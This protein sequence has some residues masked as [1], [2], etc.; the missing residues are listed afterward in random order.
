LRSESLRLKKRLDDGRVSLNIDERNQEKADDK[1]RRDKEKAL[2]E[3]NDKELNIV[4]KF[5]I[6][7]GKVSLVNKDD[8]KDKEKKAKEDGD[9]EPENFDFHLNEAL[10]IFS[11]WLDIVSKK[12]TAVAQKPAA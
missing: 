6:Q 3:Q 4:E 7:K 8:K 11:D 12:E 5:D 10:N 9:E 1:I 2:K